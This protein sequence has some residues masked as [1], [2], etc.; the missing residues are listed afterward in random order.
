MNVKI[1]NGTNI[2]KVY[3]S[4]PLRDQACIEN[5]YYSEAKTK[6]SVEGLQLVI[7]LNCSNS[8]AMATT[9]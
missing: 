2:G 9:W 5:G 8:G 3:N 6:S 4:V 1:K 7:V